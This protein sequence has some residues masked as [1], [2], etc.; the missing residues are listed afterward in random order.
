MR[1][2]AKPQVAGP[3]FAASDQAYI[4]PCK[5]MVRS[6]IKTVSPVDNIVDHV[7]RK[8]PIEHKAYLFAAGFGINRWRAKLALPQLV[9]LMP[10]VYFGHIKDMVNNR[11]GHAFLL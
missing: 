3:L 9:R 2:L 7:Q 8:A 10:P 4:R 5:R 6:I 1:V 11:R